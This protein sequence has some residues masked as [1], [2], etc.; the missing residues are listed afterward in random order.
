MRI[1]PYWAKACYPPD[2]RDG[3]IAY[4]WSFASVEEAEQVAATRAQQI[5]D[6]VTRG[7]RLEAYDYGERP[8]REEI[9][10]RLEES[11]DH[12][13]VITRNRYG[14]LVLNT[15]QVLFADLDFPEPR[16]R[17]VLDGLRMLLPGRQAQR[18]QAL[19]QETRARVEQW[20]ES[21]RG[22]QLP[23]LPHFGRPAAGTDG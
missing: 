9:V 13:A 6:R 19:Q 14:S 17:G 10:E 23:P 4:G 22:A 2:S 21:R 3:F 1:P 11:G 20:I 15:S 12:A 18:R 5:H 7:D 16:A 8:I